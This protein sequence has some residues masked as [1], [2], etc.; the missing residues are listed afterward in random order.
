MLVWVRVGTLDLLCKCM[1][2]HTFDF[3]FFASSAARS[4]DLANGPDTFTSL[5]LFVYGLLTKCEVK[6]AGYWPNSFFCVFMDRD[7]VKVHK[8]AKKERA[9]IQP[10]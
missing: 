5:P 4:V 3:F 1:L 10:S 2:L 7:G 9:N 8:L 6:M